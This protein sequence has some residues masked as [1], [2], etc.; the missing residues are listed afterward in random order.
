MDRMTQMQDERN[1]SSCS[2]ESESGDEESEERV[3]GSDEDEQED[4]RDYEKGTH[5]MTSISLSLS[6]F[7]PERTS[8]LCTERHRMCSLACANCQMHRGMLAKWVEGRT[9]DVAVIIN[10]KC[11]I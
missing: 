8:R 1:S 6:S 9:C 2:D 4:P 7:F 11:I 3:L 10:Q 5:N